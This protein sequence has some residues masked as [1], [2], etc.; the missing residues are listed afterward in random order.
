MVLP[1]TSSVHKASSSIGKVWVHSQRVSISTSCVRVVLCVKCAWWS[2]ACISVYLNPITCPFRVTVCVCVRE[3]EPA[4]RSCAGK[5]RG[6]VNPISLCA[7]IQSRRLARGLVRLDCVPHCYAMQRGA[8]HSP[9]C[10]VGWRRLFNNG[11][12]RAPLNAMRASFKP[13][14]INMLLKRRQ[15]GNEG[16]T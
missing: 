9:A 6:A 12:D 2:P 10:T 14:R 1:R 15:T 16:G 7:H 13:K 3:R 5:K 11:G 4:L 8:K